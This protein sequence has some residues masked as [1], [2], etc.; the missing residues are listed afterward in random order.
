MVRAIFI[1]LMIYLMILFY[2]K[3]LHPTM[4]F[5]AHQELKE[6]WTTFPLPEEA[7][8]TVPPPATI[9]TCPLTTTIS[10]ALRFENLLIL[11]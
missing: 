1:Y 5:F 11:V 9:P 6:R 3:I 2:P 4:K 7:S 8:I 10:P